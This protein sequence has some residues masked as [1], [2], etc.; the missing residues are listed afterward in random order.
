MKYPSLFSPL[1]LNKL[2]I[3]NRLAMAP[4]VRN[5]ADEKGMAT[6]RYVDH[7]SSL[8]K[9]GTGM[10]ILEA[11]FVSPEGR[12]FLNELGI[13]SDACVAS[14]KKLAKAA[15]EYDAAIGVQLYHGG[16]QTSS[17]TTG[18]QPVAPSAIPCP[19]MGET[20]KALKADEIKKIVKAFGKAAARAKKAGL[21]F[22][23]IHG[24]HGYLITQFLSPFSNTR[25]DDYGGTPE[26]RFRFLK[27]VYEAVREAV[28]PDYPVTVRLS[29]DEWVKGG[30]GIKDSVQIAKKLEK[31]GADALHITSSN[32][33][34]FP[35]GKLIPPMAQPD[36]VL[37][38]LAKE[39]KQNVKIPVIAVAKIRT[40]E[41]AE[42]A[43][44]SKSADMVAIGRS[45]LADPEW[46]NKAKAGKS[47]LINHCIACNQGCISRLFAGQDVWCTVNPSCGREG[48][49]AKQL[50]QKKK[51]AIIG[52]GPGGMA[53]AI[54]AAKRGHKVT[55]Y[56]K[57]K[58]LGGQLHMAAM[59]P[60]RKDWEAMRKFMVDEIKRL[61][62]EV[63]KGHEFTLDDAKENKFDAII[64][65]TGSQAVKP[66]INGV[67]KAN[68][69]VARDLYSG[70]AE[71]KGNVVVVGGGCMGTQTAE[72][73]A[74]KNHPVTIVEMSDQL[75]VEAP[76]DDRAMLLERLASMD[77]K[78]MTKT[79][80]MNI[81]PDK[82]IV[83]NEQGEQ[84][85]PMDTVVMC[86]GAV[87]MSGLAQ[88]LKYLANNVKII[89]DAFKPR[90]VT[91]AVLEGAL[92][93]LDIDLK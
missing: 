81:R 1:K 70:V 7:I 33:G 47:N 37:L 61:K 34:S 10:L 19:I 73:L 65:A 3:K 9:G 79:R 40:P 16:R 39:I 43:I 83:K 68:V 15:H 71:A 32:Y 54:T 41:M 84:A 21:D 58:E 44:K 5:Y 8:A 74:A 2:K 85:L 56:E 48:L 35:Q 22:V 57:D 69:V 88:K 31:L 55:L 20:P 82:V 80:V 75:A 86:V 38:P 25:T 30:L 93:V 51:I 42:K 92:A 36:G 64:V 91:D 76:M 29:G 14:L 49:F 6:K 89:G 90:R 67:E 23:E 11:T 72:F 24:A 66:K 17:R 60:F 53:A 45:L 50:L 26:K 59:A 63:E 12:G 18:V 27:E 4:M 28:G 13:H 52:G 46:P 78:M 62:I 77:V 87:P